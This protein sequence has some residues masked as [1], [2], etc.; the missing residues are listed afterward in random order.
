MGYLIILFLLL[1]IIFQYGRIKQLKNIIK[2]NSLNKIWN[3]KE[4]N[5][6]ISNEVMKSLMDKLKGG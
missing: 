2:N 1:Y 3:T 6:T 5:N 4:E